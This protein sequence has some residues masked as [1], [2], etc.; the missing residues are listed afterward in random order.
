MYIYGAH[1]SISARRAQYNQVVSPKR[2]SSDGFISALKE[3]HEVLHVNAMQIFMKSPRGMAKTKL[4]AEEAREFRAYSAKIG[5]KFTVAHCS[6][7]LNFAKPGAEW[8]LQ[9]LVDDLKGV[10]MLD[11]A[12]V[13]LHVGK[14]LD[15]SEGEAFDFLIK[16]LKK[17]LEET[18]GL[19]AKIILEN[20]AGQGTEM[21]R[22]FEELSAIY[23]A[24]G[25]NKRVVFCLDTC[26]AW[27][28]GY[29]FTKP[30]KVFDEFDKILG[31]K[32]L[33]L[34]HFNDALKSRGSR[35]DRHANLGEGEIGDANLKAIIRFAGRESVPMIVE[36]PD[37]AGGVRYVEN[38]VS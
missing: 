29:D 22:S 11:G 31:L 5:F 16:N 21:G 38:A 26:H 2:N 6:Y 32:N 15:L 27:A 14:H 10:E 4:T 37:I 35:V 12:G 25:K 19:K 7:L 8:A 13:V 24:L 33:E 3:A 30:E 34:I 23:S 1:M 17:V 9:S 36:T 18:D 20:T 28:W